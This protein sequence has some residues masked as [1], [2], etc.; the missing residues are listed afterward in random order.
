MLNRVVLQGNIGRDPR[1]SLTQDGKTI[2]NFSLATTQNWKDKTGE[3][4]STT[5]WHNVTIFRD[6]TVGWA[7]DVLK[8]G[9][10]VYVEGKLSYNHWIDRDGKKRVT[11]HVCVAGRDGKVRQLGRSDSNN[12]LSLP[13]N[14]DLSSNSDLNVQDKIQLQTKPV[15]SPSEVA[16]IPELVSEEEDQDIPLEMSSTETLKS[17]P[18]VSNTATASSWQVAEV[19]FQQKNQLIPD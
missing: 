13:S 3:W 17:A 16:H 11:A 7:K 5:D 4:Q 8:R 2:V 1:V 19:E 18:T 6:S 14:P 15:S 12:N 9:D 10:S